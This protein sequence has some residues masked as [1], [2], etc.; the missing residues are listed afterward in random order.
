M[1][2]TGPRGARVLHLTT[3][4]NRQHGD[5]RLR[6]CPKPFGVKALHVQDTGQSCTCTPFERTLKVVFR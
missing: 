6:Q 3:F 1:S 4:E 5:I 2:Q